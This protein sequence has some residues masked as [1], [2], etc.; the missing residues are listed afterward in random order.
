MLRRATFEVSASSAYPIL[1]DSSW[2]FPCLINFIHAFEI[3]TFG[4]S[5]GGVN[6]H[7]VAVL[8]GGSWNMPKVQ[9]IGGTQNFNDFTSSIS[10]SPFEADFVDICR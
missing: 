9:G 4:C 10:C 1:Y 2:L 5:N 8:T 3:P 7:D 6:E